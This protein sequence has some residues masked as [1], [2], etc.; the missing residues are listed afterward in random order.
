MARVMHL[1]ELDANLVVILD[2]LLLEASVTKAAERL[3]RSPSAVSHALA[4]L[5]EVFDDPLFVRAGQRLVPTSR[6]TQLAPTVHVIVAGLEGLLDNETF[7]DPHAQARSF[8][9]ACRAEMELTLL[10]AVRAEVSAL[11]PGIAL[12]RRDEC[13]VVQALRAGRIDLAIVECAPET[14]ANDIS[15]EVLFEEP[16]IALVPDR[17][18]MACRSLTVEDNRPIPADAA[19]ASLLFDRQKRPRPVRL[20]PVAS[21]LIALHAAM[22][23]GAIALVPESVGALAQRHMDLRSISADLALPPLAHR[24]LWHVSMERDACHAWLRDQMRRCADIHK[25]PRE[26]AQAALA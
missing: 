3:G 22:A 13:D 7:L 21:P 18:D 20:E 24:I 26:P 1:R 19:Q 23:R 4:R 17:R 8:A 16:V 25:T 6:A 10:P 12:G 11:A 2:A 14:S 15:A 9:I 5:R